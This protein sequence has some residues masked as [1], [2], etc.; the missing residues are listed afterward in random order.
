MSVYGRQVHLM[1]ENRRK[2]NIICKIS[3]SL[4]DILKFLYKN[5][6]SEDESG[7]SRDD[8]KQM[9]TAQ[10]T[11]QFPTSHTKIG[12]FAF[13]EVCVTAPQHPTHTPKTYSQEIK[14][15]FSG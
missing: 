2:N 6:S 1:I 10:P 13:R 3:V 14:Y 7:R 8:L 4:K 9:T 11:N 15:I 12:A 5:K